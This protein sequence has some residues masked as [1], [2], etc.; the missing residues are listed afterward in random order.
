MADERELEVFRTHR[1]VQN[2]YTYFLLAAAGSGIALAVKQT[3]GST[4]A[5]SQV[6]LAAAVLVWAVSFFCGCRHVAYVSSTLYANLDLL[7][8]LSGKHPDV[9]E[10]PWKIAA[11]SEGINDAIESN[12]NRANGYG[13]WQFR[14][15]VAG[16]ALYVTWHVVEMYLRSN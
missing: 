4:M 9:G 16:A 3:E 13:H 8:V 7:K 6:P 10:E 12:S 5:W 2:R 11:A 1:E 15:L 14:L